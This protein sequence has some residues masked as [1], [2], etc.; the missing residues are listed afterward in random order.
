MPNLIRFAVVV[1][2][3][4]VS[5]AC[6]DDGAGGGTTEDAAVA[7]LTDE[8]LAQLCQQFHDAACSMESEEG[9]C[10]PSCRDT[11]R[12][13]GAAALLRGEC[14]API[15]VGQVTECAQL[16][17]EGDEVAVEVCIMGGGCVFD[18]FDQTCR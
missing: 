17:G 15:T 8:E 6:G 3:A 12:D 4:L 9:F 16:Y 7:D 1:G 18:V 2:L 13:S 14:A 10:A 5:S 11:C